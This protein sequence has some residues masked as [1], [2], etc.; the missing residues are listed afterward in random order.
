MMKLALAALLVGAALVLAACGEDDGGGAPADASE[1]GAATV[2][3]ASVDSLGDVLVESTGM[4]LYTSDVEAGGKVLCTDACASFWKPL[5]PGTAPPT[6]DGDAGK[7]GVIM[8]PDGRRQVTANG[9]PLYTFAEDGRG[10]A[11]GDGFSDDF[12]GRHFVWHA[13]AAGGVPAS[14][15]GS[16]GS[17]GDSPGGGY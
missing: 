14:K 3:V 8:R 15:G 9:R 4:T 10:E 2:S 12:A 1:G 17:G 11:K 5:E 7:L 13:V 16:S 6:T